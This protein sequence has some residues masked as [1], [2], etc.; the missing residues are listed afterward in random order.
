M[1]FNINNW[2][3]ITEFINIIGLYFNTKTLF[4][5]DSSDSNIDKKNKSSN[6][7]LIQTD[8]G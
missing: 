5:Q 7:S 2:I 6:L 4:Y 8:C 3:I 1:K